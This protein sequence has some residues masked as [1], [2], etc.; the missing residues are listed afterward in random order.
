M[1]KILKIGNLKFVF[2]DVGMQMLYKKTAVTTPV[3]FAVRTQP[4]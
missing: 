3:K 1:T 2:C 4:S